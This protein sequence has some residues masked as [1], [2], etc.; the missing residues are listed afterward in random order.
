[1]TT[2]ISGAAGLASGALEGLGSTARSFGPEGSTAALRGPGFAG[3]FFAGLLLAVVFVAFGLAGRFEALA[4]VG[5]LEPGQQLRLLIFPA[6]ANDR[7]RAEALSGASALRGTVT[8]DGQDILV[9]VREGEPPLPFRGWLLDA[10]GIALIMPTT[11]G[12]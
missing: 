11:E 5:A 8:A 3:A 12:R 9:T 4:F 1:M 6:D 7:Q 2:E 10:H